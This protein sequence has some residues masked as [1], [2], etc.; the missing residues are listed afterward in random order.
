MTLAAKPS[1]AT[2]RT[3]HYRRSLSSILVFGVFLSG[4]SGLPAKEVEPRTQAAAQVTF[5]RYEVVT[6]SA[7]RQTIL[8]GFLLGGASAELAEI[9]EFAVVH[10]DENDARR[11]RIYAFGDDTWAPKLDTTLRPEVVFVDVANIGGRDRLITYEPGRLNWF[12]ANSA[13]ERA[14]VPV[15]I[16][17]QGSTEGEVPHVDITRDLNH[18]DLVVPDVDGFWISIQLSNGSFTDVVKLG[19]PEPFLDEI[20]AGFDDTRSYGEVGV[21]AL[22][23]PW[24]L[25]RVH[26]MDYDQ[27]GRSDLA[28]WNEDHFEVHHQDTRGLFDPMAETFPAGVPFDSAGAY[29]LMFGFSDES[30]FSLVF[31]FRENTARTV[32]HSLRDLNGD[33]VADLVT[34]RLEGRSLMRQ[35]SLYEVHF[36]TPTP[37]GTLFARDVSTAIQPQG[38]RGGLQPW[39]YSSQLF[40]D[41]DG[42]GQGDIVLREVNVGIGGI[43]R[44]LLANSV[45][46]D[47]EFYRFE[48]GIYP[49]KPTTTRR[50]R[51]ALRPFS[52]REAIFFPAALMG[53][54]NGDGRSDLLVAKRR[55]ELHVF[56]GVPGPDLFDR[57]PQ[58]L[59]V[60]LPQDQERNMWLVD[61]NTDGKQDLFM[62]H[63]STTEPHRVTM[64]I[65]R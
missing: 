7:Q 28:F 33:R 18:D 54:V 46:M 35:R 23:I 45:S 12:D 5:E 27:D 37:D 57:Q 38:K 10:I 43:V 11:L 25:S 19:P 42:D 26:E 16:N 22:T 39:G 17:Y 14:L 6:G 53:D 48:D 13:T 52:G 31:G 8:T 2:D 34:H 29:S 44:A 65:A 40:Q 30:T 9:A 59:A 3:R 62:H 51:P 21:S 60:G 50:I 15:N 63:P 4:C 41:F 24:Y 58:K 36:G 55:E 61:L 32:L 20:A 56:F 47:L 49:D 1:L 64:L